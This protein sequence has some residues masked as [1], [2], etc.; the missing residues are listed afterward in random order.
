MVRSPFSQPG[1]CLW[2]AWR[3]FGLQLGWRSSRLWLGWRNSWPTAPR[4]G[5]EAQLGWRTELL[6]GNS[7]RA[8]PSSIMLGPGWLLLDKAHGRHRLLLLE[9]FVPSSAME[10][11]LG[12]SCFAEPWPRC[13]YFIPIATLE[14]RMF[15]RNGKKW[16]HWYELSC[17]SRDLYLCITA[18]HVSYTRP[19]CSGINACV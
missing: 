19:L 12:T 9:I 10:L 3:N 4:V 6:M 17:V 14:M 7:F 13:S 18:I 5:Q 1:S 15:R 11:C 2:V 8:L 16:I